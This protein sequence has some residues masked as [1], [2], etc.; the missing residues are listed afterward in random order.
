VASMCH[1]NM[2]AIATQYD[3]TSPSPPVSASV[4]KLSVWIVS[5]EQCSVKVMLCLA[6]ILY[7]KHVL[8]HICFL[9]FSVFRMHVYAAF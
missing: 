5:T 3:I 8:R 4:I 1:C 7:F 6:L 2:I 9:V